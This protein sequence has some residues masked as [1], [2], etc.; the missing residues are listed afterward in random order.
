MS[1][2]TQEP[3]LSA[4]PVVRTRSF[5]LVGELGL[6]NLVTTQDDVELALQV[7][8][9]L[10]VGRGGTTLEVGNDG[11]CAVDLCSEVLLCHGGALVVLG[12]RASL[13]DGLSDSD[14]D[15]LGLDDVVGA[16]DLGQA[17]TFCVSG[18]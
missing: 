9:Q 1:N 4:T 18:L 17:L 5:L 7:A 15:G 11:W 6:P 10:L 2:R 14:T 8:Q 3:R 12:F 16:I 13:G